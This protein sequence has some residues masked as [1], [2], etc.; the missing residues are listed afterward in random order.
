M[1]TLDLNRRCGAT[2]R[3]PRVAERYR[4][5]RAV[6]DR[7]GRG[8]ASTEELRQALLHYRGIY[9]DLAGERNDVP[10]EI[11]TAA[12][13]APPRRDDVREDERPRV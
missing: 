5:G 6:I 8:K 1:G 11:A 2:L 7:H 3:H 9:E 4:A 13:I 12:E 10:T